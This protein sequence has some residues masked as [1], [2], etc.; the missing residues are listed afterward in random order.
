MDFAF[1]SE[2]GA[3][4]FNEDGC[5]ASQDRAL[6]LV[7]DG[8]GQKGSGDIAA[9]IALETIASWLHAK[10]KNI[11]PATAPSKEERRELEMLLDDGVQLASKEILKEAQVNPKCQGISTTLDLLWI[12]STHAFV[13]HVGSGRIYLYRNGELHQLTEDHT[14]LAH[15][16]RAGKLDGVSEAEQAA[17][18]KRLSRA[19]G[20]QE[21]VKVDILEIELEPGDKFALMSDGVWASLREEDIENAFK[22]GSN[23]E[24]T[25]DEIHEKVKAAG[26]KDNF[27]S[28]V[29]EAAKEVQAE[30]F[31]GAEQKIKMLGNV[32]AF[33]YLSYQDLIKVINVGDL[34]KI[35]KDKYIC[36][37]GDPGGEM[38]LIL[39]GSVEIQK[40]SQKIRNLRRGD[41]FGELSMIDEAPRSASVLALEPTNLLAFPRESLFKLFR[42]QPDLAV[43][44]LWGVTMETNK[45]LRVASN[46]MVGRPEQEGVAV[47]SKGPLPFLRSR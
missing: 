38:M 31:G 41:V 5:F 42:E 27:T 20:F 18:A 13:A 44:F 11:T 7:C 29:I 43:K 24:K 19:V 39:S 14:H 30:A 22:A 2:K 26:A 47:S 34:F 32:P 15:Y 45:R 8:L 40:N 9:R 12:T 1:R 46:K 33:A 10:K 16:R 23:A 6:F 37:E 4:H 35:A 36:K 21:H 25:I 28:I 17:M 3:A